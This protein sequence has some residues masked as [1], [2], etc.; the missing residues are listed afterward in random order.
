MNTAHMEK[1][2]QLEMQAPYI[3]RND[4][5]NWIGGFSVILMGGMRANRG[6][7]PGNIRMVRGRSTST[8]T[9]RM[10]RHIDSPSTV[11]N[12][13]PIKKSLTLQVGAAS[14]FPCEEWYTHHEC[15]KCVGRCDIKK[16]LES[17]QRAQKT[18]QKRKNKLESS[19]SNHRK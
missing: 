6:V 17:H 14:L 1:N 2:E 13:C 15:Q 11:S 3:I 4:S 8:A 18:F 19:L 7:Y 9:Q 16:E 12:G 5:K 10:F